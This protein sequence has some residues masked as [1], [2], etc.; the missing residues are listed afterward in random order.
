MPDRDRLLTLLGWGAFAFSCTAFFLPVINPDLFW[1]LSA[2]KYTLANGWP[3]RAD[4]LSW[5]LAGAEWVDFEWLPQ[6]LYYLLHKA[7]GFWALL[8][9]K[10][11]LLALTLLVFRRTALLY[12]RRAALLPAL[13]LLAAAIVTNSDLRPENFTLLFFAVTLYFLE[14]AR[15]GA[16]PG[17]WRPLAAAAAFFALWTNLHAGYLYGLALVGLYAAGEFFEEELPFIYGRA[18]FA[19]PVKSPRYLLLFFTGLL[20]SLANP[21]GWKIYAVIANHQRHIVTLQ[22]HIQ[23]WNT[24]DLTNAYQWPYV[25]ALG[26]VLGA[27]AYFL[28]RRRHVVYTHFAALLFFAWASANHAR[29]IPFFIIT[30]LAVLLALP[31]APPAPAGPRRYARFALAGFFAAAL[32]FFYSAFIWPNYTGKPVLFKWASPGLADFLRANKKELAGLRLYNP[33]GWGGWLG[34][35]LAPDYKVFVDGRYLFHDKISEVTGLSE[36][37]GNWR[38]LIKKYGFELV[39]ITLDEPKVPLK[40]KLDDGTSTIFWRPAYLFYLPRAEWAVVYWDY[41]V[42]ALVRRK[43]V[44]ASWLAGKEFRYLRPADT[45][46]LVAPLL[47]GQIRLSDVRKEARMYLES[48]KAAW[49]HSPRA[50]IESFMNGLEKLCARKGAKCRR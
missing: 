6:V 16:L 26:G 43:T 11:V 39:L 31:W 14:R 32:V 8:V 45:L 28:L 41:S 34:W 35:E 4:F 24:F 10:G 30:G 33:W 50:D 25:L 2:G 27:F 15:L 17:G 46:N 44:P 47:A 40:Q 48:N 9:F 12:G 49:E 20:A 38:Q 21:Y 36:G 1:H 29:H 5:P 22:E 42:A 37:A 23:E 3:P 13:P 18:P 19:R 7:G